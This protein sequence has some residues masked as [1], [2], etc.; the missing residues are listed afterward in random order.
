MKRLLLAGTAA[1]SVLTASAAHAGQ[2]AHVVTGKPRIITTTIRGALFPPPK[3]DKPY[4]GE[5]EIIFFSNTEM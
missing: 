4:D 1:L 3:Y 5:L 2:R